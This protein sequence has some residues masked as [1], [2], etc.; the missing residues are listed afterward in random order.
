MKPR[1]LL[2]TILVASTAFGAEKP[3]IL[4][5][6][7]EPFGGAAINAAKLEKAVRIVVE[8]TVAESTR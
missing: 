2:L 3:V 4:L 8:I 7:F 1:L 5:T 6:G